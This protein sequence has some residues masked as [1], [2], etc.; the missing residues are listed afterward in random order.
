MNDG[1]KILIFRET[2]NSLPANS[3][4]LGMMTKHAVVSLSINKQ[5]FIMR[6]IIVTV[7]PVCHVGKEIPAECKNPGNVGSEQSLRE[8]YEKLKM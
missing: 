3:S 6:K 8:V 7:A 4:F 2:H 5:P 1:A